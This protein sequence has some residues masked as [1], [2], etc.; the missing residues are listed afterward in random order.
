MRLTT[1]ILILITLVVQACNTSDDVAN[2]G[3]ELGDFNLVFPEN[4][5]I[6]TEGTNVSNDIVSIPFRWSTSNNATSYKIEVITQKKEQKFE[7]TVTTNS[8]EID[9]PKGDQFTWNVIAV[10]E[11]SSKQS[12]ETWSF[13]SE[14][15]TTSDHIPFPATITLTDNKDSTITI[16]WEASDIDNDID[17]YEVYIDTSKSTSTLIKTTENTTLKYPIDYDTIYYIQII[18]LDKKGNSSISKKEFKFTNN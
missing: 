7:A 11:S 3:S 18:T 15:M 8:I 17:K 12:N 9:I 10:K 13:Y 1:Y 4:G 6:C 14:G 5:K 16:L 2:L